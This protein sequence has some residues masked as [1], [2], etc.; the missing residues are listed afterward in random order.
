MY[1]ISCENLLHVRVC[2]ICPDTVPH[3]NTPQLHDLN[4]RYP[5][6]PPST[7]FNTQPGQSNP[8]QIRIYVYAHAQYLLSAAT[9]RVASLNH[10]VVSHIFT[11]ISLFCKI[12]S[13]EDAFSY[14]LFFLY[15]PFFTKYT[16]ELLL[17]CPVAAYQLNY[18]IKITLKYLQLLPSR[19]ISGPPTT[20]RLCG[21]L[22]VTGW[23]SVSCWPS[24]AQLRLLQ[25]RR[26]GTLRATMIHIKAA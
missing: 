2:L 12:V 4:K 25:I 5:S 21:W 3:P 22:S 10:D 23:L 9:T 8:N 26:W 13:M 15:L 20:Q 6:A 19:S 14:L 1:C 16:H 7:S 24:Q 17:Q 11:K 18:F